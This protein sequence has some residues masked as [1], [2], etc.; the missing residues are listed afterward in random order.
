[1]FSLFIIISILSKEWP[2]LVYCISLV[3]QFQRP[4]SVSILYNNIS[5]LYMSHLYSNKIHLLFKYSYNLMLILFYSSVEKSSLTFFFFFG[6]CQILSMNAE[7]HLS[8]CIL[9][10]NPL[11]GSIQNI[12]EPSS[13]YRRRLLGIIINSLDIHLIYINMLFFSSNILI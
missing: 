13:G 3:I 7:K 2:V 4:S 9:H 10:N 8:Y 11:R 5:T 6:F 12:A 1:M